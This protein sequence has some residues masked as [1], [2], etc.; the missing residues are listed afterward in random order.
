MYIYIRKYIL[1]LSQVVL[2]L[3]ALTLT[4]VEILLALN[5]IKYDLIA[6]N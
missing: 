2:L 3:I 6:T 5:I 4:L 1:K